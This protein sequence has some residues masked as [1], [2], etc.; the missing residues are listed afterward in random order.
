MSRSRGSRFLI[1]AGALLAALWLVPCAADDRAREEQRAEQQRAKASARAALEQPPLTSSQTLL[2]TETWLKYE[3]HFDRLAGTLGLV[4]K[5]RGENKDAVWLQVFFEVPL[6]PSHAYAVDNP[7]PPLMTVAL[8]N[9][10]RAGPG[11]EVRIEA[12]TVEHLR[13]RSYLVSI[14][15]YADH[16]GRAAIGEHSQRIYSRLNGVK[17]RSDTD[18]ADALRTPGKCVP[19]TP[20]K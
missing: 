1:T 2:T 14:H 11:E 20:P 13:C 18:L 16:T 12:P 3:M 7:D 9:L 4:V 19:A 5:A 15:V 17:I 6:T 8:R 10:I